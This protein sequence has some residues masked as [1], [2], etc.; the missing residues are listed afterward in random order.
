VNIVAADIEAYAEEHSTAPPAHLDVLAD[1][2]R[3]TL[4]QRAGMMVGPHE[5]AFLRMLVGLLRPR[6]VLEIGMFTGYSALSMAEALPPGGRIVTCDID[7]THAAIA[8]KHIAA[9]RH[10]S[11]IEI[12]MGPALDTLATLSGPFDFVFIDADKS[13]YSNYYEAV[14]PKLAPGGCI[15]ADNVLWSGRVIRSDDHTEDT[16]ALRRFNDH[17][18]L[19]SRVECVMVPIRDGVTLI[20]KV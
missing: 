17:V 19:D 3:R 1:E 14:L 2:T 9:S 5:G 12:R 18:R 10:A 6:S 11:R 13:N 20:R 16:V 7:E 15:A 4:A 8:R